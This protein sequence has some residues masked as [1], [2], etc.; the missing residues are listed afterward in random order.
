MASN[1]P[2]L[3]EIDNHDRVPIIIR[4]NAAEYSCILGMQWNQVPGY[5]PIFLRFS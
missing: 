3:L 1:W 4:D 5:V 2:N